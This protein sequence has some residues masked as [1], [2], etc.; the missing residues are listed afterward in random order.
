MERL[1]IPLLV[2]ILLPVLATAQYNPLVDEKPS[3]NQIPPPHPDE[4]ISFKPKSEKTAKMLTVAVPSTAILIGSVFRKSDFGFIMITTGIVFGPS[5]GNVYAENFESVVK[6]IS[7]RSGGF[8]LMVVGTYL[9]LFEYIFSPHSDDGDRSI[10][11]F[12]KSLIIGG[13]GII[14]YS[15]VYDYFKSAE[16][17]R[18][19]NGEYEK[20]FFTFAPTYFPKQKAPGISVSLSF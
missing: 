5:A 20:P 6:G 3:V 12:P 16:N 11:F 9:G 1:I 18:E 13:A 2:A 14:L 7:L 8:G 10:G 17:V 19:Y 4:L 15:W